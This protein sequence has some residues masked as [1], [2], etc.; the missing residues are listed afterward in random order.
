M[1]FM[2]GKRS[3][4]IVAHACSQRLRISRVCCAIA[5]SSASSK[6]SSKYHIFFPFRVPFVIAL[7][8]HARS[9][10][11]ILVA[12]FSSYHDIAPTRRQASATVLVMT[13]TWSNDDAID[14]TPYLLIRPYVGFIP[15]TPH[16][17]AGCLT[18]QPVSV[19]M[20][21]IHISAATA[22][23]EPPDDPPGILLCPIGLITGQNE[24]DS[25]VVPI[26]N[27]SKF[28]FP[29]NEIP[30]SSRRWKHVALYGAMKFFA[31]REPDVVCT[32]C[33]RIRSFT[34]IGAPKNG[35]CLD[36]CAMRSRAYSVE[37]VI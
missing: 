14:W 3:G 18:D 24:E 30:I 6:N 2:S 12:S 15:T 36:C 17:H 35:H 23:A 34:A 21:A 7:S 37:I 33:V 16:M 19:P 9:S 4:T 22:A 20:A 13:H 25:F 27:S 5:G 28:V 26:A 31:M 1:Y 29:I 11:A 10:R 8:H 32:H